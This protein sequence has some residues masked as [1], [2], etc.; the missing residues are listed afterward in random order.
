MNPATHRD[1]IAL[2]PLRAAPLALARGWEDRK[3]VQAKFFFV[4]LA[5]VVAGAQ[6]ALADSVDYLTVEQ[7]Q[8]ALFPGAT[9]QADFFDLTE[10]QYNSLHSA[11]TPQWVRY[12]RP[13]RVSTG[14][15]FVVDQVL[16]RD[17]IVVYAVGIDTTGT[18]TGVE[19]MSCLPRY[20]QVRDPAWLHQLAGARYGQY[21]FRKVTLI[22]GTSFSAAHIAEGVQRVL[23]THDLLL[24]NRR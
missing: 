12:V 9:F 17:D 21:N 10:A 11:E 19:V 4:P 7:A 13:W 14:G 2:D 3:N 8:Q 20:D 6:P 16:G 1:T 23:R 5:A 15:W 18:V 24:K 22:S